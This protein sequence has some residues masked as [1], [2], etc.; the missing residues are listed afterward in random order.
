M[1]D[2]Q[3]NAGKA[4]SIQF[5][6]KD[7]L[8]DTKL[9]RCSKLAKGVW[10]DL[11]CL[12]CDMPVPGVFWCE[13]ESIS[14][15][16]RDENGAFLEQKII[17]MLHGKRSENK[18]GFEQLKQHDIIKQF[19][20]GEYK[21]A[22][23][24]KRVYKDTLLR[25]RRSD[26]GKQGGNPKF[27]KGK[28]NP[29][30]KQ[31]GKQKISEEDKQKIDASSSSSSSSSTAVK[32]I[33]GADAPTV[34]VVPTPIEKFIETFC[35]AYEKRMGVSYLVTNGKDHKL[36]KDLIEHYGP[37]KLTEYIEPFFALPV[38]DHV[39]AENGYTVG[40]FKA[41]IPKLSIKSNDKG[42]AMPNY[43]RETE[44]EEQA[45]ADDNAA[46]EK[47]TKEFDALPEAERTIWTDKALAT[48]SMLEGRP[49]LL[50]MAAIK[51]RKE[52]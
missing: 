35:K 2:Y 19:E 25:Q 20:D 51:L 27:E 21:G 26:A 37:D 11:I 4:P 52:K 47:R 18:R 6:W 32:K 40:T 41:K 43:Q 23:Y 34:S 28:P 16:K 12:S 9:L 13:N 15:R 31:D 46:W 8:T 44:E 14:E 5:Y 33:V 22:F 45:R 49:D 10:I 3:K 42:G 1:T 30:Y 29:Y 38:N 39:I 7:W 50:K 48:N 24:V 17:Q 36:A